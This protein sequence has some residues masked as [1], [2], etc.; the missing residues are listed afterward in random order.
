[1]LEG[2]FWIRLVL[3]SRLYVGDGGGITTTYVNVIIVI[4]F[5]QYCQILE[6]QKNGP[7]LGGA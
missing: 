4:A 1:M 6:S 2:Y 7:W 5:L 3:E